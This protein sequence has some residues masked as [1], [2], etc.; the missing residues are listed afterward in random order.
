MLKINSLIITLLFLLNGNLYGQNA[1]MTVSPGKINSKSSFEYFYKNKLYYGQTEQ[2]FNENSLTNN[3]PIRSY[4]INDFSDNK[5]IQNNFTYFGYGLGTT[6]FNDEAYTIQGNVFYK[7]NLKTGKRVDL[8][9]YPSTFINGR[10]CVLNDSSRYIY[11][12]GGWKPD[13]YSNKPTNS[14]ELWRYDILNNVWI[15]LS[16]SLDGL[17]CNSGAYIY[18]NIYFGGGLKNNNLIKYNLID[19]TWSYLKTPNLFFYTTGIFGGKG[20][21]QNETYFSV[22]GKLK[23]YLGYRLLTDKKGPEIWT[24][25]DIND[26][27][28]SFYVQ[29]FD[30]GIASSVELY[31]PLTHSNVGYEQNYVKIIPIDSLNYF[32]LEDENIFDFTFSKK[33]PNYFLS[34]LSLKNKQIHTK[35]NNT[36]CIDTLLAKSINFNYSVQ[37][38]GDFKNCSVVIKAFDNKGSSK[39]LK[40]LDNFSTVGKQVLNF[41]DSV[42]ISYISGFIDAEVIESGVKTLAINKFPFRKNLYNIIKD[43]I[44]SSN[45]VLFCS[46]N[47]IGSILSVSN[48]PN[49]KYQWYFNNNIISGQTSNKYT[50]SKEGKYSCLITPINGCTIQPTIELKYITLPKPNILINGDSVICQGNSTYLVTDI[51]NGFSYQWKLNGQ[52]I[53]NSTSNSI[54]V[55]NS[56]NYSVAI[57]I[58]N[59]SNVSNI[60]TISVLSKPTITGNLSVCESGSTL[61]K[62]TDIPSSSTPWVS[63]NINIATVNNSGL[64]SP[65]GLGTCNITFTNNN[66]CSN[67]VLLNVVAKPII[68]GNLTYCVGTNGYLNGSDI[69][70]ATIPWMSN[71]TNIATINSFGKILPKASGTCIITYTNSNGCSNTATLSVLAKPTISGSLTICYD[72][73]TTLLGSDMPS[74]TNAWVSNNTNIA[75]INSSG[76]VTAIIPGTCIIT[77]TNENGCS[78]S[79]NLK[80]VSKPTISGVLSFCDGATTTLKSS[81]I[82]SIIS[83]WLSGNS[84]ITTINNSGIVTAIAPGACNITYTN[85]NGCSNTVTLNVLAKPTISGNL[86]ICEGS[87]TTLQGTGIPSSISPWVSNNL[88]I[89]SVNNSGIVTPKSIGKCVITYTNNNACTNT[90]TLS[91]LAKPTI[92]GNLTLCEGSSTTLQ[93]TGM[94]STTSPWV[95]NNPSIV[96]LSN[97]GIV[98]PISIGTTIISYTNDTGCSNTATLTILAKPTISGNLT[99]C[100]GSSSTLLGSGIPSTTSPWVSN[101]PSIVS[102]NNSGLVSAITSG[103]TIISYSNN[104]GCIVTSI[105]EI[106]KNP[107]APLITSS[108]NTT[109]C[110]GDSISLYSSKNNGNVWSNKSN[111]NFIYVKESGLYNLKFTDQNGCSSLLSESVFVNVLPLPSAKIYSSSSTKL[112]K[113]EKLTLTCTNSSSYLWSNAA[114]TQS[115][116][117]D[118]AG[119]YFVTILGSNGC[120]NTSEIIDIIVNSPTNSIINKIGVDSVLINGIK[121]TQSGVFNQIIPNSNGCDSTI[122]I[123]VTIKQN[124]LSINEVNFGIKYYPNPFN[125]YLIIDNNSNENKYFFIEDMLGKKITNGI[126]NSK[127]NKIELKDLSPGGY[128]LF[129]DNTEFQF[130]IIKN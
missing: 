62:S 82:P 105:I 78:N 33:S 35:I 22:G 94:P 127:E 7:I 17:A 36:D 121:Y 45:G 32:I 10:A 59:C 116:V 3:Q 73:S 6:I 114:T 93:G 129:I 34:T 24:Y 75:T 31:D 95:S 69:P 39:I 87:T 70:S 130:K 8:Q 81:D 84:N 61:L 64:I 119:K 56:G 68:T 16:N 57:S 104:K 21:V 55:T 9:N 49:Y 20:E 117:V 110:S 23:C 80:I 126:L 40:I 111:S 42:P 60:K 65:T 19:K 123:N 101:N 44:S 5:E 99:L 98:T 12:L 51:L 122:T 79:A 124:N 54:Q 41:S 26:E 47:Q 27:W 53:T 85:E 77:Y 1:V 11:I 25:D 100:E 72:G 76:I 29:L 4:S 118:K 43:S 74:T 66:G 109:F 63:N 89:L 83:P 108:G 88:S 15:L 90:I 113:G 37:F 103:S 52:N 125:E 18:P 120:S 50:A 13:L 97:S 92:S 107:S 112:C 91:V 96:S 14:K 46:G 48:I 58:A 2:P 71:N 86:T 28:S 102:V 106:L 128:F 30:G 38:S 67:S 115:I